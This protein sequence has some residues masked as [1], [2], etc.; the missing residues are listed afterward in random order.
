MTDSEK[1]TKWLNKAAFAIAEVAIPVDFDFETYFAEQGCTAELAELLSDYLPCA[2]GRGFA[3]EIGMVLPDTYK[4]RRNDGSLG[5]DTRYDSD[6]IWLIVEAFAENLRT[7]ARKR[8][9]F[10]LIAQHSAEVDAINHALN[11]GETLEGLAGA[12]FAGIFNSPM[13]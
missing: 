5:E 11:A 8:S 9:Q 3:R 4:R 13:R 7:D 12:E 6:P 2:C 10:S 1:I